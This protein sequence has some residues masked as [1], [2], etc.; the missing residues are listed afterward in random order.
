MLLEDKICYVPFHSFMIIAGVAVLLFFHSLLW[1][2]SN[3]IL[4]YQ[5]SHTIRFRR[6]VWIKQ[7]NCFTMLFLIF[8]SFYLKLHFFSLKKKGYVYACIRVSN[9]NCSS[10]LLL[11]NQLFHEIQIIEKILFSTCLIKQ[12]FKDLI[13]N[14]LDF[15]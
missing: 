15:I 10:A 11:I 9:Y 12:S 14:F 5:N 1:L 4:S 6:T 3:P 13:Q 7:Q 8:V 2:K